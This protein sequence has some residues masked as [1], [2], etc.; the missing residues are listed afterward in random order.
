MKL[1]DLVHNWLLGGADPQ[2]GLR[3]FLDYCQVQKSAARII[4]KNPD[5][6][7]Q[8]IK[9]ALLKKA[10]LP[11]NIVIAPA[12]T[13]IASE[14]KQSQNSQATKVRNQWP[15]LADPDCP[16]ELKL[17]ISDKITAY[18]NCV[19]HYEQLPNATTAQQ[20]LITVQAL[21]TNFIN[22]HDI[23]KELKHY[24]DTGKI[25]GQHAIFAQYQRILDLR[26]LQIMDLFKKKQNLEHAIWRTNSKIKKDKRPDL[27]HGRQEK[28]KE[29]KMQLAE[30]DR[31]L[32]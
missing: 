28:L 6:H 20:Q 30:V 4:S 13:V 18:R 10:E 25:L 26:N 14:A 23:Y 16:P 2:V 1:K 31:L 27:L 32:S 29:F 5:M 9:I 12:S 17:L 7:L 8:L 3:L 24:K 11:Y 19:Q 21:V 15:F 22:N